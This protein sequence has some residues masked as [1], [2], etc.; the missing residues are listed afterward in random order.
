MRAVPRGVGLR[1]VSL[2]EK[3]HIITPE[4]GIWFCTP[5]SPLILHPLLRS[6]SW[7]F[8]FQISLRNT[9]ALSRGDSIGTVL[10]VLQTQY[11]IEVQSEETQAVGLQSVWA[12]T[13]CQVIKLGMVLAEGAGAMA[14]ALLEGDDALVFLPYHRLAHCALW[15][16]TTSTCPGYISTRSTCKYLDLICLYCN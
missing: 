8:V 3:I 13:P 6:D 5:N 7:L 11:G 12:I 4:N 2:G 9:C 1:P 16:C 10:L 14:Y 15:S